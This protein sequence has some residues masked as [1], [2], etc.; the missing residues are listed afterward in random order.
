[1]PKT[2]DVDDVTSD[3]SPRSGLDGVGKPEGAQKSETG[4]SASTT[5][6]RATGKRAFR[7]QAEVSNKSSRTRCRSV[8]ADRRRRGGAGE[9]PPA[10][11]V[12]ILGAGSATLHLRSRQSKADRAELVTSAPGGGGAWSEV[13]AHPYNVGWGRFIRLGY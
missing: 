8:A 5:V 1:M 7:P 9:E 3:R 2:A 11:G 6:E 12:I 4:E 10:V 13:A